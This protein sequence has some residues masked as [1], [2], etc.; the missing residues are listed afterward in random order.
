MFLFWI[1]QKWK[2]LAV[3]SIGRSDSLLAD[4]SMVYIDANA[5][6]ATVVV[7]AVLLLCSEHLNPFASSVL[8]FHP[9][10]PAVIRL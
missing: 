2:N 6:L 3:V 9:S 1:Q 4:E 10:S 8:S 7:Y 5:V